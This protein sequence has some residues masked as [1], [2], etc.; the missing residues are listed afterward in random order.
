MSQEL[1]YKIRPAGRHLLTIGRDLIQDR[2]AA[3]I[4]LVKN[5]YDADSPSVSIEFKMN[6]D[7]NEYKVIVK[8]HGHGMSH[9]VVTEKWMVPST[10]DKLGRKT[11]PS[12]RVMQGRKG[13]GRYSASILGNDLLLETI[14]K[15]GEKTTLLLEWESFEKAKFLEDVDV[16]IEKTTSKNSS[17]TTL[18][19]HQNREFKLDWDKKKLEKLRYELK[20]LKPPVTILNEKED[21]F[22][23]ELLFTGF[24]GQDD[25][26][27]T[28]EPYPILNLYDYRISGKISSDGKGTLYY[29][30]QKARN[31]AEEEINFDLGQPTK[32]GDLDFDIRVYDRDKESIDSLIRRGLKD[33]NGDYVG[34]SEARRLLDNFNGVGVYRNGF[35]IRPLG[36]A[37]FDWLSLNEQRVQNP[38]MRIGSNQV[39]GFVSLQSEE[40]SELEEKSARDGLKENL[41][42]ESLKDITKKVIVKLEERRFDYRS[43]SGLSRTS[44]KIEQEIEKLFSY[45]E[46]KKKVQRKLHSSEV[47]QLVIDELLQDFDKD[48]EDKNKTAEG[49]RQAVAIYQGQVTLGKIINVIL[50]EGRRPL[51][52]FRNQIPRIRKKIDAFQNN[53]TQELANELKE[54]AIGIGNNAERFVSLFSRL[55]PLASGKRPNR[56]ELNLKSEIMK[57]IKIFKSDECYADV[58]WE[59]AGDDVSVFG[60]SQDIV[61]VFSNLIENSLYWMRGKKTPV[62]KIEITISK[63]EEVFGIDYR[64]TGPGIETDL[65]N[66]NVIF[67]PHFSTKPEGTGLGLSIAGEAASRLGMTIKSF[68]SDTGVYFRLEQKGV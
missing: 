55:D 1:T 9:E 3:V 44:L 21:D 43:K 46:L 4:E 27:E 32:C 52:Y 22:Q 63:D 19:I 65:I 49:I 50:H 30:Q 8:D 64:D 62:K 11:S 48:S 54:I 33:E 56:K 16:L 47:E 40:K 41:A 10:E 5:A 37:D 60:W 23:I 20:K 36:D 13:V 39:I 17:G 61:T 29:A 12:G 45:E 28:I 25:S 66:R 26:R 34:K 51:S 18:T 38:S 58:Q 14:T 2:Y 67:E 24:S 59:L 35:R 42:Y 6:D 53:Q 57:A 31:S 7:Q 15:Q 68:E